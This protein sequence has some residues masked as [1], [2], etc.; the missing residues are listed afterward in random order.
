MRPFRAK[1]GVV[2]VTGMHDGVV[3]EAVEDLGFQ[4]IQER[5][6]VCGTGGLAGT[7]RKYTRAVPNGEARC[8]PTSRTERKAW[9]VP[10]ATD[11][12]ATGSSPGPWTSAF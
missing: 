7:T 9:D 1:R 10:W 12:R 8:R 3:V 4:I 6:E 11:R 2:T 5:R